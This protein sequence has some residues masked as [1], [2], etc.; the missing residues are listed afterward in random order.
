MKNK[1]LLTIISFLNI[2]FFVL[3]FSSTVEAPIKIDNTE[4]LLSKILVEITKLNSNTAGKISNEMEKSHLVKKL[5]S[6]SNLNKIA[7]LEEVVLSMD[8][9]EEEVIFNEEEFV[10]IVEVKKEETILETKEIVSNVNVENKVSYNSA[11]VDKIDDIYFESSNETRSIDEDRKDE[12]TDY[13]VEMEKR[14]EEFSDFNDFVHPE[15]ILEQ[16]QQRKME[17]APEFINE[18]HDLTPSNY[19]NVKD[20]SKHLKAEAIVN[21]FTGYAVNLVVS[22]EELTAENAMFHA[23]GGLKVEKTENG[24]YRYFIDNF[25]TEKGTKDYFSKIILP[26]FP[27]AEV[28]FYKKG[29]RKNKTWRFFFAPK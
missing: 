5:A 4:V 6:V 2:S 29:Q 16:E 19:Y 23:F 14:L 10:S 3:S 1:A 20:I 15:A 17:E 25:R 22:N 13:I 27:D 8:N 9:I 24:Q 7:S 21:E 12:L 18:E 28:V 26:R 11:L